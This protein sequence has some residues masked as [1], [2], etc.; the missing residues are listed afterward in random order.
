MPEFVHG[1]PLGADEVARAL[2]GCT[3]APGEGIAKA[4]EELRRYVLTEENGTR[5]NAYVSEHK[6]TREFSV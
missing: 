2:M 3:L 1:P 6:R 4:V 5:L